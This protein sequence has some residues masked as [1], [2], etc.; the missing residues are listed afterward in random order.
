MSGAELLGR[1]IRDGTDEEIFGLEWLA[2][3]W[4][5]F[6]L[7]IFSIFGDYVPVYIC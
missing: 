1:P 3:A 7:E 6:H 2:F 5:S 4:S